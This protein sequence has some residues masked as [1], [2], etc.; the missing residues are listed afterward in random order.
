MPQ[1]KIKSLSVKS[2]TLIGLMTAVTCIL[3]PLSIPLPFSPVPISF[4]NLA[5]YLSVFVLGMKKG[6]VS[7]I[8]YLLLGMVGLPVFSGFTGGLGKLAGPTGGYLT[9]FIFLAIIAGFCVD[10]G[11]GKLAWAVPGMAAGT[12][13]CYLF[14]TLWLCMQANLTFSAGLAAGVIPYL[15]GDIAKIILASLVGPALRKGV[16]RLQ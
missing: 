7:Y 16:Q 11:S 13:V 8:V 3:G 6:T 14:G 4:T 1:E 5:I 12:I 9:G 2:L 15:P 10:K